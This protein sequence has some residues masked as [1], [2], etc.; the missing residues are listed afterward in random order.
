MFQESSRIGKSLPKGRG[1]G[2]RAKN[3]KGSDKIWESEN[4]CT[5]C[6]LGRA[7]RAI[8]ELSE[9]LVK[10]AVKKMPKNKERCGDQK[11]Y[12]FSQTQWKEIDIG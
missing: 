1:N 12:C 4:G 3:E 10:A 5:T 7:L 11:F 6:G 8:L 2:L 9:V